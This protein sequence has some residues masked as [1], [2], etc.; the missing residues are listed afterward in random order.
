MNCLDFHTIMG[1]FIETFMCRITIELKEFALVHCHSTYKFYIKLKETF[2][3][4]L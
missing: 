4:I 1:D 2:S 3:T